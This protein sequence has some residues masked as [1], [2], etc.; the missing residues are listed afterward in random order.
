M[1]GQ[2]G[3][4]EG[5]GLG[6]CYFFGPEVFYFVGVTGGEAQFFQG[7]CYKAL[8]GQAVVEYCGYCGILVFADEGVGGEFSCGS[9]NRAEAFAFSGYG[10]DFLVC[11]DRSGAFP[12]F[13]DSVVIAGEHQASADH[14][15]VV[16]GPA[17][18]QCGGVFVV[19]FVGYDVVRVV[20]AVE[21]VVHPPEVG[22][23]VVQVG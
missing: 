14:A 5:V 3:E 4:A 10:V 6:F 15:G 17:F 12:G 8:V 21:A 19:G 2:Q 20:E 11:Q 13:G 23:A 16:A 18:F 22:D 1:C 7:D 9:G